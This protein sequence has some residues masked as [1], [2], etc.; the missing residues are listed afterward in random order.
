[1]ARTEAERREHY[2]KQPKNKPR[3]N[4]QQVLASPDER[5]CVFYAVILDPGT[6][7]RIREVEIWRGEP[8]EVVELALERFTISEDGFVPE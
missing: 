7:K 3:V 8:G 1:M 5:A 6:Q 4:S 2:K